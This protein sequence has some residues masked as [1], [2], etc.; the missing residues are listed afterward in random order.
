MSVYFKFFFN[1][2][3][4]NYHFCAAEET[5]FNLL[6]RVLMNP[7]TPWFRLAPYNLSTSRSFIKNSSDRIRLTSPLIVLADESI[8]K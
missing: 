2:S 1:K 7:L 6:T 8:P 5:L 3:Y 4:K